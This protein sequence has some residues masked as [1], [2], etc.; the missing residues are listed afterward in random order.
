[1]SLEI[2]TG[3]SSFSCASGSDFN[4]EMFGLPALASPQHVRW[5]RMEC[6]P[7]SS[8]RLRWRASSVRGARATHA[9]GAALQYC[10]SVVVAPVALNGHEHLTFCNKASHAQAS[11]DLVEGPFQF[12]GGTCSG[13]A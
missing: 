13:H 5:M 9:A 4:E 3:C 2:R 1:M 12:A 7:V 8:R 10:L 6:T 11:V